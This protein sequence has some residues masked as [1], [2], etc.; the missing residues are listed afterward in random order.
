[1]RRNAREGTDQGAFHAVRILPTASASVALKRP[2]GRNRRL[3]LIEVREADL[4]FCNRWLRLSNRVNQF[5]C[6]GRLWQKTLHTHLQRLLQVQRVAGD[7]D[8][9]QPQFRFE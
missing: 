3:A 5:V 1:M 6:G 4:V 2:F 9:D 7:G 8:E